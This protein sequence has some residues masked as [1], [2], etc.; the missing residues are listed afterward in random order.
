MWYYY[1]ILFFFE[2]AMSFS[3]VPMMV[4]T[5]VVINNGTNIARRGAHGRLAALDESFAREDR[6]IMRGL[7]AFFA[8][9]CMA[10]GFIV[11]ESSTMVVTTYTSKG[12]VVAAEARTIG[13]KSSRRE[14]IIQ[15]WVKDSKGSVHQYNTGIHYS[16][17]PYVDFRTPVDVH[18]VKKDNPY[19]GR[20]FWDASLATHTCKLVK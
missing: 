7:F 10:I 14:G 16:K 2:G 6:M 5:A 19:T 8:V 4:A 9:F 18:V 15:F 20:S 12:M 1:H 11:W 17:C 3:S 13:S